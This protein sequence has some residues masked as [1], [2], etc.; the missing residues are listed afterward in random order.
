MDSNDIG[1]WVEQ[2]TEFLLFLGRLVVVCGVGVTSFYVF[3]GQVDALNDQLPSL[4]YYFVPVITLI[5][6]TWFISSVFFSVYAMAIDTIFLCFRNSPFHHL[7]S[8]A[9]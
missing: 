6:G 4:N 1:N 2:V 9:P 8:I 3:S 5:I 7:F